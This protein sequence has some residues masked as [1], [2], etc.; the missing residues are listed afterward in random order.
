MQRQRLEIELTTEQSNAIRKAV[1]H[2]P[3]CPGGSEPYIRDVRSRLSQCLP[4][5]ILELLEAQRAS[6]APNPY[7]V[8]YNL[9]TDDK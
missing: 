7:V 1:A 3:Y 5:S 6:K 9:P 8:I 2:I 4:Q